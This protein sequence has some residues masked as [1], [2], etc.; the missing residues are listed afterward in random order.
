[1]PGLRFRPCGPDRC[2]P[3]KACCDLAPC[4][5]WLCGDE[6]RVNAGQRRLAR[7]GGQKRQFV[8][9]G[10]GGDPEVIRGLPAGSGPQLRIMRS[11]AAIHSEYRGLFEDRRQARKPWRAQRFRRE[12]Y[13]DLQ[14]T[15]RHDTDGPRSG[16]PGR[17]IS[18]QYARVYELRTQI[19]ASASR[20]SRSSAAHAGSTGVSANS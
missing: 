20:I 8:S 11:H 16:L 1:M 12:Q 18:G 13:A 14:L 19:V 5:G 15:N 10:R 2:G 7:I 3:S 17:N 4:P 6:C 9:E